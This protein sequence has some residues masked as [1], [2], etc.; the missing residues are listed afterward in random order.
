MSADLSKTDPAALSRELEQLVQENAVLKDRLRQS[1]EQE[2][3]SLM[4]IG[5]IESLEQELSQLREFH[6]D[7]KYSQTE[8]ELHPHDFPDST[9]GGALRGDDVLQDERLQWQKE[10]EHLLRK[11]EDERAAK[12]REAVPGAVYAYEQRLHELEDERDQARADLQQAGRE[13]EELRQIMEGYSSGQPVADADNSLVAELTEKLS[14]LQ[15]RS[16]TEVA[17]LNK[18]LELVRKTAGEADRRLELTT[19]NQA[20]RQEMSRLR[21]T[22]QDKETKLDQLSEQ[23]RHLE[24]VLEDKNRRI[25]DQQHRYETL[26]FELDQERQA[27]E[28]TR[29]QHE[30]SK[31][32][33]IELHNQHEQELRESLLHMPAVPATPRVPAAL[34]MG[35][36]AL[37]M[38]VVAGGLWFA[39]GLK[40]S[41]GQSHSAP[42]AVGQIPVPPQMPPVPAEP[43]PQVSVPTMESAVAVNVQDAPAPAPVKHRSVRDP[44]KSGPPGPQMTFINPAE[45]TMGDERMVGDLSE[46]PAHKVSLVPFYIGTYEITFAEYERFARDQGKPVPKDREMGRGT[47]PVIH[48]SWDDA[49]AY[50]AWLSAQTG[51]HYRLPTEAEWEFAAGG[52]ANRQFWWGSRLEPNMAV[53]LTCGSEWDGRSTAPVGSFPANAHGLHDTTG[54]VEEWVQDCFN[55]HYQGAPSDGRA[56]L[57]GDCGSRMA[58]G[59]SYLKPPKSMRHIARQ[60]YAKEGQ[61]ANVGFRLARDP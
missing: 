27:H 9:L 8:S 20:L 39:V 55:P 51:F 3:E 14:D 42:Q 31:L 45:F 12:S 21:S 52:G 46:R 38:A 49:Q 35:A 16:E 24:D 1:N 50:A 59:G 11:L 29:V 23:C 37:V 43:A 54:N 34:W 13:I 22:I 26:E 18:E 6:E 61:F 40:P 5:V 58:R 7:L 19:E 56:W 10:R 41:T 30:A 17:R 44:L 60:S 48:V 2:Q 33:F 36:G 47:R 4:Q 32:S 57:T 25:D 53:C 15:Y 28:Q